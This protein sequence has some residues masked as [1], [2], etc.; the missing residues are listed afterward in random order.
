M[1]TAPTTI[2]RPPPTRRP[3]ARR[4]DGAPRPPPGPATPRWALRVAIRTERPWGLRHAP[5]WLRGATQ[6]VLRARRGRLAGQGLGRLG[7][8]LAPWLGARPHKH[9]VR[10]VTRDAVRDLTTRER[11]LGLVGLLGPSLAG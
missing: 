9:E 10:G 1:P 5:P 4:L 2:T 8:T 7:A 6:R 3:S 11:G